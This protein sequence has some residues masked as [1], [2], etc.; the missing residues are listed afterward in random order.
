MRK[1]SLLLLCAGAVLLG[2]CA[3]QPLAEGAKVARRVDDAIAPDA[4]IQY[5]QVVI[6]DRSLQ[7]DRAGKLAVERQGARRTPTG[8]VKVIAQFRNRTD[9]NQAIEARVSFFDNEFVPVEKPSAW[10]RII[11]SP[12]GTGSYEES[13]TMTSDVAHYLVEVREAR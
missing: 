10:S 11:L 1:L 13:S 6:L 12:N 5:D 2:G 3:Q 9:F 8:T 7:N 4:R